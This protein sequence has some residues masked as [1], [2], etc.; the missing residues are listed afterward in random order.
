MKHKTRLLPLAGLLLA[1]GI[2]CT[3]CGG[4][5]PASS[6]PAA[7][8]TASSV[9]EVSAMDGYD[10]LNDYIGLWGYYDIDLWLRVH[11]DST[12]EFVNSEDE[13]IYTGTADADEYGMDLYFDDDTPQMRLDLSVSG[14]LLEVGSSDALH[15]VDAIVSRATCWRWGLRMRCTRWMPS[16]PGRPALRKMGWRSMPP[17]IP[18]TPSSWTAACAALPERA[19]ATTPTCATGR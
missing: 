15:P 7:V 9:E 16:S 18:L 13:A 19:A 5:A 1:G 14:D 10:Y 4:A 6:A 12:F 17:W 2:L 3:G 8:S 11:E